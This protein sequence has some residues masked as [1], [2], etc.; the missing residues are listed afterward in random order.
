M[1]DLAGD[2]QVDPGGATPGHD[3]AVRGIGRDLGR[4]R[5][6]ELLR[7]DASE[8]PQ[9]GTAD[10]CERCRTG[11]FDRSATCATGD[12]EARCSRAPA[13][14]RVVPEECVAAIVELGERQIAGHPHERTRRDPARIHGE[15]RACLRSRAPRPPAADP[16]IEVRRSVGDV[17][18]ATTVSHAGDRDREAAGTESLH[19]RPAP[20][21]DPG[22]PGHGDLGGEGACGRPAEVRRV[23]HQT[24]GAVPRHHAEHVGTEPRDVST[25]RSRGRVR[26]SDVE[27]DDGPGRPGARIESHLSGALRPTVTL[28]RTAQPQSVLEAERVAA[29]AQRTE[30]HTGIDPARRRLDE[31]G[32]PVAGS[33][34]GPQL[35]RGREPPRV[36]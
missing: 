13:A 23:E 16:Q 24:L 4:S 1:S 34:V 8:T 17:R 18:A 9:R 26:Q 28:W 15:R 21:L 7:P 6:D 35:R 32:R 5:G 33:P 30:R 10:H 2:G 20:T 31:R 12:R 27:R 29:E 14:D 11:M 19:L 36:R 3:P 25:A 22:R